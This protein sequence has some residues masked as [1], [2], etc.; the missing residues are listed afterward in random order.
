MDEI[1][2]YIFLDG[3]YDRPLYAEPDLADDD[4]G[5]WEVL[6]EAVEEATDGDRP[7]KGSAVEGALRF[8]WRLIP[9]TNLAFV[10]T[11][12]ES[13][14]AAHLDTYMSDLTERY[15]DEIIDIR[16]PEAEGMETILIDV[17]A[18]WEDEED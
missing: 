13:V 1:G 6:C 17:V 7:R 3:D 18:P 9:K 16:R 12:D 4:A 15:L 5:L 14:S 2:V 10:V 8:G 11:V